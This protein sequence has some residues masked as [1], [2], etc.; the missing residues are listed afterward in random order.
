MATYISNEIIDKIIEQTDIVELI[1]NYLPL[2]KAGKNY[3][4]LCPFHQERTPSFV[5]SPEKQLFH[6]FGCGVGGN[7]ISFLMRWEKISFPEAVKMLGDKLGIS[8]YL[9]KREREESVIKDELYQTNEVIST[10]FQEE[11]KKNRFVQDYLIKRGFNED[12]IKSFKLGYAPSSRDFLRLCKRRGVSFKNL[13]EL[14]LLSEDDNF[15]FKGRL[16]FPIFTPTDKISGFGGRVL[17]SSL[18][19]YLNSSQSCIFKKGENLYGLNLSK[20]PIRQKKEVILVEGY[21]DVVALYQLGLK[22]VVASL[23]T[24]LTP[25]QSRLIKR[26]ANQ[27]FVAYDEDTAGGAATLRGID[28]LLEEDLRIKVISMPRGMDPGDFL[29]KG[30]KEEFVKRKKEALSYFDYRLNLEIDHRSSLEVEEKIDV[31]NNLFPTLQK[32][33]DVIKLQEL[34]KK[35]AFRLDLDESLLTTEFKRF[36]G[37]K[38]KISSSPIFNIGTKEEEKAEKMLL[39]LML[40]E[41]RVINIVIEEGGADNFANPSYR[42]IAQKII[43]L[44]KKE[45][46]LS[47]GKL[48]SQLEEDNLSSVVSSFYLLDSPFGMNDKEKIAKDFIKNLQRSKKQKRITEL[49]KKIEESEKKGEEEKVNEWSKELTK[50]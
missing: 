8:I 18:P 40:T 27:I 30:G 17:D 3:K 13:R 39:Q 31:I 15:Y 36:K 32:I 38:R 10:L 29:K 41:R 28:L 50:L 14:G 44:S 7:V 19:K 42:K 6:C 47:P 49:I 35:L 26:Y 43:L 4:A 34:I 25:S 20:E 2:K 45:D 1:S 24:S 33:R 37:R 9:S 5:V 21:T 16:I 11:L 46:I 22:N 23:G 48:I 12:I